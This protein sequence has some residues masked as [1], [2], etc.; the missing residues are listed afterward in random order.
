MST[1]DEVQLELAKEALKNKASKYGAVVY[2]PGL[3]PHYYNGTNYYYSYYR[4]TL[5]NP[6]PR[7]EEIFYFV[8]N[9][10]YN[11]ASKETTNISSNKELLTYF[12]K[13]AAGVN[14]KVEAKSISKINR[15]I[16]N[17]SS[18]GHTV[19]HHPGGVVAATYGSPAAAGAPA[20]SSSSSSS[21]SSAVA[22][23]PAPSSAPPAARVGKAAAASSY[24]SSSSSSS[25]VRAPPG[26]GL[27]PNGTPAQYGLFNPSSFSSAVAP[28]L[29]SSTGPAAAGASAVS[30]P[31][32]STGPLAARTT[33]G[34]T[35]TA[36][37]A[38]NQENKSSSMWLDSNEAKPR[39]NPWGLS[40]AGF[41]P[42]LPKSFFQR[43]GDKIREINQYVNQYGHPKGWYHADYL[44]AENFG[45]L[46]RFLTN[47]LK[48]GFDPLERIVRCIAARRVDLNLREGGRTAQ[49]AATHEAAI[50]K[51]ALLYDNLN[52][53][54]NKTQGTIRVTHNDITN[55][56][57][58]S[59]RE[60]FGNGKEKIRVPK[61]YTGGSRKRSG[62]ATRKSS[63][64]AKK[65]TRKH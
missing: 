11:V 58:I 48:Q 51:L 59:Y 2:A 27:T 25:A 55:E 5:Y 16:A 62:K 23:P 30:P 45:E 63:K 38:M 56:F 14:S 42:S 40:D 61:K 53:A 22:P 57:I 17:L 41:G 13:I 54:M 46:A 26:Y 64:N 60:Y 19:K 29:A 39:P 47:D 8:G 3:G 43:V 36:M 28:P 10:L 21:S 1:F 49:N 18:T 6:D 52:E 32:V 15:V 65:R 35:S 24:P 12:T 9:Q 7:Q 37:T 33:S 4:R 20:S 50:R 31:P 44:C 34:Y